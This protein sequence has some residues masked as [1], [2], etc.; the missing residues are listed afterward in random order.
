MR[1]LSAPETSL[2]RLRHRARRHGRDRRARGGD[3]GVAVPQPRHDDGARCDEVARPYIQDSIT[4]R[5][6]RAGRRHREPA[7]P[8][9]V[10]GQH[11]GPDARAAARRRARCAPPPRCSRARS[12]TGIEVLPEDAAAQPPPGVAA[13]GAADVRQRPAGP[14]RHPATRPS[15]SSRCGPTLDYLAPDP[16]GLQLRDAVVPQH[17]LAAQRGRP[18]RHL[19]AVHHRHHAAGPEQRG[20][21]VVGARPTGRPRPTTCTPTRTRTRR[22]RASRASARR[23]TSRS[24]PARP[25]PATSRAR[26]RRGPRATGGRQLMARARRRGPRRSNAFIGLMAAIAS[27]R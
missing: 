6:A 1:N 25:S 27:P 13:A 15:S 8:A 12:A 24:W 7:A 9:A 26:S 4:E 22:R 11:R 18:Q 16:D 19:A 10:P 17:L 23:A 2:E 21:P 3:A 14:A 5:Q 20:R